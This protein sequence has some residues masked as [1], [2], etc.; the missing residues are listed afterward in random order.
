MSKATWLLSAL[1][2]VLVAI[3]LGT[4]PAA[5]SGT[6]TI[7]GNIK[8]ADG[9]PMEGVVVSARAA[10]KSFATSVFTDRL[11]NYSF[12]GLDTGKYQLWAQAVGFDGARAGFQLAGGAKSEHNLTLTPI[13][14][15]TRQLTGTEFLM[16]LPEN[17]PADVRMK[18]VFVS[19]CIGCHTASWVLQNR[20]DAAGW[21][22]I[23]SL[24]TR[25]P[26]SGKPP[27]PEVKPDEI[28]NAYRAELA[29]WLGRVRGA[30]PLTTFK[31]L[32]RPTGEAAQIVVTEFD[33]PR[34][35][36]P[37][38]TQNGSDW[39][40]GTP[41]RYV[42]RAAH[43]VWVDSKGIV[44]FADDMVPQRTLG[45]LD[46]QTGKVTDLVMKDK[47]GKSISTHSLAVDAQDRVWATN[48]TDGTFI[49]YDQQAQKF[50]NFDR[51]DTE[52]R[53]GGTMVIDSKGNPWAPYGDGAMK[54]DAATG[55]YTHYA[56][57]VTGKGT[58]GIAIDKSDNAWYSQP[59]GDRVVMVDAK[60]GESTAVLLEPQL[61]PGLTD[62]DRESAE[63]LKA[64]PNSGYPQ[65]KAPRRMGGDRDGDYMWVA[66]FKSDALLR[67]D[68]RTRE[69]K[70]YPLPHKYSQPYAAAVA[71]DHTVWLNCINLDR[72][73]KFDPKTEK[74]TEYMLPTRG[75]E[76]RH[77]Q[78]D[79]RTDPP[80]VWAP[81]DR[82]NKIARI[83]FRTA[84]AQ[85]GTK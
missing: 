59:G 21:G 64:G 54:L 10:D 62:K 79:N 33:L 75:T 55:T 26:S 50:T 51:P 37:L 77:I 3:A 17:T 78:F 85:T 63:K 12:P 46:P 47:D 44:W 84:G 29:I 32:P 69:I 52:P 19:N 16:S 22:A 7:L 57:P 45:R 76:I 82:V 65:Q 53:V 24:M 74:F 81:F 2:I 1:A 68:T 61:I 18:H 72:V 28:M 15:M 73:V 6:G 14:D 25:F 43:D 40:E 83:Q 9:K 27:G 66:E 41:S 8:G 42:G 5:Q 13:V 48:G 60:T 36:M 30:Q 58:Y 70:E 34:P 56:A 71:K 31:T 38:M 39:N 80:T 67:I 4:S 35:D 49:M 23:V 11:G 20:F